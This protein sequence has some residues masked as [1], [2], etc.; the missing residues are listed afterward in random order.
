MWAFLGLWG[1]AG[2]GLCGWV[3]VRLGFG[4]FVGVFGR[5]CSVW[6]RAELVGE[7]FAVGL[8]VGEWAG[9]AELRQVADA[10]ESGVVG[11]GP[12][13]SGGE[14]QDRSSSVV[15][16][17]SGQTEQAGADCVSVDEPSWFLLGDVVCY[18]SVEVVRKGG[19]GK[20]GGVGEE[21]PGWAVGQPGV[22]F[23]VPYGQLRAG[24]GPVIGIGLY[25]RLFGV[26]GEGVVSP[27]GPQ[28]RLGGIG[29]TGAAYHHPHPATV[30]FLGGTEC[31]LRH[32][33]FAA[34]GIVDG[35]P[36]GFLNSSDSG[37]DLRILGYGGLSNR[38]CE[39]V[40]SWVFSGLGLVGW[41]SGFRVGLGLFSSR[42]C[43]CR[44]FLLVCWLCFWRR[45]AAA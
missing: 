4:R 40:G 1:A 38:L 30:P 8:F 15:D 12:W 29:E 33:G 34:L 44:G 13:P 32:L 37:F 35:F 7:R 39:G 10:G 23:D 25:G 6:G 41:G 21:V 28:L 24:M 26:G 45:G 14:A 31:G 2:G 9:S 18:P 5:V 19:A 11:V 43:R 27:V 20:P 42:G 36:C 16:D 17:S 3:R 22:V